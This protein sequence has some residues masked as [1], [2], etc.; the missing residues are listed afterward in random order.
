MWLENI[1][2]QQDLMNERSKVF[3]T[4]PFSEGFFTGSNRVNC[5]APFS[6]CHTSIGSFNDTKFPL[7]MTAVE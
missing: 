1:Q 2:K 7:Q 4:A 6:K 3:E 5:A